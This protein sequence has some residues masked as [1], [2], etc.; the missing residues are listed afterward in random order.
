MAGTDA[1]N[2][3]R[4]VSL[5]LPNSETFEILECLVLIEEDDSGVVI[6]TAEK[7]VYADGCLAEV[8][9]TETRGGS[10]C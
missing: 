1:V 5:N 10:R 9:V 2:G 6:S 7:S 8:T 4:F 3:N